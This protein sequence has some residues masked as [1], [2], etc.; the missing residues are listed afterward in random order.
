MEPSDTSTDAALIARILSGDAD[1]FAPLVGRYRSAAISRALAVVREPAEA[2]D[3]AQESF[4]H[5]YAQLATC[6]DPSKFSSWFLTLVHRRALNRLRTISR[7]RAVPLED[8]LPGSEGCVPEVRMAND[9]LRRA[10]SCALRQLS[11]LQRHIV[12]L[13]DVERW[14][15]L[16]IADAV[17][18]SVHMSRRHLSDARRRLRELL[19]YHRP[20]G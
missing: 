3:V 10:L 2:E 5:A 14:P 4:V 19:H 6:R 7:R 18:V 1:A 15:H 11:P 16:Q 9:E 13:A 12:L 20:T 8:T 17:G